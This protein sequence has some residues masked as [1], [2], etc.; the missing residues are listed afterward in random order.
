M[1][2]TMS[3]ILLLIALVLPTSYT[4]NVTEAE[5]PA[6]IGTARVRFVH[7]AY[8]LAALNAYVDDRLYA[9]VSVN[10]VVNY[11]D[12]PAGEHTFSFR[13]KD[14]S[15]DLASVIATVDADQRLTVV[16]MHSMDGVA[17]RVY[18]DDVSAPARN[19]SRVTVIH[20]VPDAGAMT[21]TIDTLP[22]VEDLAYSESSA[23]SPLP[24]GGRNQVY[25]GPHDVAITVDGAAQPV[26]GAVRTF[27]GNRN[28]VLFVVG[29]AARDN[30]QI[31]AAES[32]VLKPEAN[33][34]FRFTN[35]ARGVGD[36]AVYVNQE[37]VPLF[38]QVKFSNV[39]QYYVTG[40]GPHTVEVYPLGSPR[41]GAPL[42][43]ATANVG[44]DEHVIFVLHGA[45]E[46]VTLTAHTGDL[47]PAAA[48]SARLQV[49]NAA[50]DNPA[51]SVKTLDGMALFD[52]L[53]VGESA[54]REVPAGSYGFE[55][56]AADSGETV[57]AQGGYTVLP[58]TLTL[59]IALDDDPRVPLINAVPVSVAGVPQ[60]ALI[61]W[62]NLAEQAGSVDV[63]LGNTPVLRGLSYKLMIDY[64]LYRPA[65][66]TMTVVPAGS[67]PKTTPP[68]IETQINLGAYAAPRT[69]YFYGAADG[70]SVHYESALDN[71]NFLAADQGR[72]RF[73][74][75]AQN[76]GNLYV[77]QV[78]TNATL[79]DNLLQNTASVH[80]QLAAGSRTYTFMQAGGGKI[81]TLNNFEVK[82]SVVYTVVLVGDAAQA[83]GIE[84]LIW[85]YVP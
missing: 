45:G 78:A 63:Y 57:M 44:L 21:V 47:S 8:E 3:Y 12:V 13:L 29:S 15:Q 26:S 82:A 31:V 6:Q 71:I 39:T 17:A 33:S 81:A 1:K 41:E 56:V 11:Q 7:L 37:D 23:D 59:L 43:R 9:G 61:R 2:Q 49:I 30:Y 76:T 70:F 46:N 51:F 40:A 24:D 55:F 34:M 74:N 62:A 4:A 54:S 36:V 69:I 32:T 65:T 83:N 58:G 50:A 25:D 84:F 35:M 42:A 10:E 68:L 14:A 64:R 19:A 22:V 18:V 5:S 52:T 80:K 28:V 53:A 66:Y 16:L 48:G 20:A 79:I 67:D 72:I 77:V 27:T 73:I 60:Y 85:E 75:A 38:P